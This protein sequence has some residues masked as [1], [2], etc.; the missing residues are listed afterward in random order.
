MNPLEVKVGFAFVAIMGGRG[1]YLPAGDYC[2]LRKIVTWNMTKVIDKGK[3]EG[4]EDCV[5][6]REKGRCNRSPDL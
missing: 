1:Q 3:K 4:R 2:D 6:V 5:K